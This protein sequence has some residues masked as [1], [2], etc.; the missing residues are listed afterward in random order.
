MSESSESLLPSI[1]R[2]S[3]DLEEEAACD[4]SI[5]I[6]GGAILCRIESDGPLG[7]GTVDSRSAPVELL[8]S[9]VHL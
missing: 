2:G 7:M 4:R 3:E 9:A 8:I 1:R 6:A 5:R